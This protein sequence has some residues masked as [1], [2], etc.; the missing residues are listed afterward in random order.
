MDEEGE[1]ICC[2]EVNKICLSVNSN[3]MVDRVHCVKLTDD[4]IK[5]AMLKFFKIDT[6]MSDAVA[7][8]QDIGIRVGFSCTQ[9][10]T[11]LIKGLFSSA[12]II[13]GIVGDSIS[14]GSCKTLL[15]NYAVNLWLENRTKT[16]KTSLRFIEG[17]HY[18]KG[19]WTLF[20]TKV[21]HYVD[22][23]INFYKCGGGYVSKCRV[24]MI[25][26]L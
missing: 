16:P 5:A 13:T 10:Q 23:M 6:N 21:K 22:T 1:N 26:N 2:E 17:K 4:S 11:N 25:K 12:E 7:F 20:K 8:R 9:F 14:F 24:G 3:L 18:F 19:V 15:L